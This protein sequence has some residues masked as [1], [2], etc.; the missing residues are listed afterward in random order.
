MSV[1]STQQ[2]LRDYFAA[3]ASGEDLGRF[4]TED[5]VWVDVDTGERFHGRAAV[6]GHIHA[7]HE[8]MFDGHT[9]AG[10]LDV[11][12]ERA[13]LEGAFVGPTGDT[14]GWRV[15]F[16]VVYDVAAGGICA[17]RL[18]ASFAALRAHPKPTAPASAG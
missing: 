17:M 7:L 16:C 11:T 18:Y 10:A 8:E 4:L 2:L 5:V 3:M 12:A 15:P 6:T 9:E 13:Y 14:A 1:E